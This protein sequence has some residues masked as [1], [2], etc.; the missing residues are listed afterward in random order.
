M[1]QQD[2][3]YDSSEYIETSSGNKVSRNCVLCGSQNIVLNGKTIVQ[4]EC[5]FRGD[6]AN[7][8]IGRQCIIGK[9]TILSPPFK[10]LLSGGAFY[11]LQVGDYTIIG[12]DTIINASAIGAH[13]Y[14]GK[15]CIIV[16]AVTKTHAPI[17]SVTRD[18]GKW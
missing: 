2:I 11:P 12:D 10:K 13:V 17:L 7:I 16:S 5:V 1:E 18:I 3:Y 8:N 9:R 14:I 6:L 15:D 4:S